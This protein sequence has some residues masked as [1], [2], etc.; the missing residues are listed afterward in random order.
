MRNGLAAIAAVIDDEAES[1]FG[2]ALI[3]RD[4]PCSEKQMTEQ[5][6]IR[7]SS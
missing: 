2:K 6:L 7:S 1:I 4:F 3:A 5:R